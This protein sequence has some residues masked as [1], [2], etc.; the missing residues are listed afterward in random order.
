MSDDDEPPDDYES[1]RSH[2]DDPWT[3]F[4]AAET[5]TTSQ[6]HQR[7]IL[8]A[9]LNAARNDPKYTGFTDEESGQRAGLSTVEARRRCNNLRNLNKLEFTGEVRPGIEFPNKPNQVSA[10]THTL[11]DE[12]GI[13]R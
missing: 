2:D 3:S 13:P 12:M 4:W 10:L 5:N 7:Q 6:T 1:P 9:H 11:L 8:V